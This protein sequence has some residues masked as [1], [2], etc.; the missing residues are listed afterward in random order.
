MN[1]ISRYDM[2]KHLSSKEFKRLTGVTKI[3]FNRML[4]ILL[5]EINTRYRRAG[6]RGKLSIEDKLLMTLEHWREYRTYFHLGNSYGLS[7]TSCLR[8]CRWV[9]NTLIRSRVFS[10]PGKKALLK[11]G[12]SYEIILID[13]SEVP[14]ER[15]KKK[16][17]I[18]EG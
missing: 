14:I 4:S 11:D 3:V 18:R 13:A 2:I 5:E 12:A 17:K 16:I 9:E 15:P 8:T 10:L 1:R 7:E 6:R